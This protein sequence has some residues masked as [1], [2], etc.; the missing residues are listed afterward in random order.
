MRDNKKDKE[1][2]SE[3]EL[4]DAFSYKKKNSDN[5]SVFNRINSDDFTKSVMDR[6]L[7]DNNADNSEDIEL[8][9]FLDSSDEENIKYIYFSKEQDN[10]NK[11]INLFEKTKDLNSM[12]F[13]NI[14]NELEK[15]DIELASLRN[16]KE[17]EISSNFTT[18]V[19]DR[20]SNYEPVIYNEKNIEEVLKGLKT[21]KPVVPSN[22]FTENVMKRI[23]E[24][25]L[26]E[27]SKFS[28]I[29]KKFLIGSLV[30]A[31]ASIILTFTF[32]SNF[33]ADTAELMAVDYFNTGLY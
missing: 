22:K 9:K 3:Q 20:I 8:N 26:T 13:N 19:M 23:E 21:K 16:Y 33:N 15:I 1:I 32:F 5:N 7:Q 17:T 14:D 25:Y 29:Y 27:D 6:I 30:V 28:N 10:S 18:N 4:L 31:A 2:I 11:I 12:D 24:S